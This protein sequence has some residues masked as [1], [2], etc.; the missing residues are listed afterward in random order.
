MRHG[1]KNNNLSRTASHR[2]AL[3]MNLG[4][5]LITFKRITTTLAKAKALRSYIEPLLT[6][7]KIYDSC[8]IWKHLSSP[9][10]IVFNASGQIQQYYLEKNSPCYLNFNLS[11]FSDSSINSKLISY[12]NSDYS[13]KRV[14]KIINSLTRK[15]D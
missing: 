1:N 6:K 11:A 5:Q 15:P 12:F 2:R 3:L 7:T 13:K 9:R 4:C 14:I 8:F 10:F